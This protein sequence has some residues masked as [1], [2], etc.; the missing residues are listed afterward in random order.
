MPFVKG[1]SG[2]PAGRPAGSR[3]RFTR[4][5]DEALEQRGLPV[6]AAI[7]QHA[8]DANPAAMRLCFDRL[9][10]KHRPCA[11]ELPSVETADYTVAALSEIQRAL[12][13]SEVTIDE[14][15]RLVDLVGRTSR[16]LASKAAAEMELTERVAR[17][18]QALGLP[19][20]AGQPDAA[21]RSSAAARPAAP[22]PAAQAIANN[23]AETM[24]RPAATAAKAAPPARAAPAQK[25]EDPR[26]AAALDGAV[27]A[28][29][30]HVRPPGRG[31]V[32]EQL[33]SSASPPALLVGAITEKVLA[34]KTGPVMPPA[35]PRAR[36]A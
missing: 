17:C 29:L 33:M 2:N 15:S 6:I 32:K 3:N 20:E 22:P 28:T 10:R 34:G 14:A 7:I 30:A 4:E 8:K 1:Q 24:S 21:E 27:Q 23:N 36:A 13:S 19:L 26:V 12:G 25:D 18:E 16:V 35:A 11:V 31:S 9:L 5:M